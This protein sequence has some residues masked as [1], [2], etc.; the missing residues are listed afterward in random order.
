MLRCKEIAKLLS[1]SLDKDL[2]RW[3]KIEI[4]MHLFICRVCR[5]YWKQLRFL[6]KCVLQYYENKLKNTNDEKLSD[7]MKKS[8]QLQI[9]NR[10]K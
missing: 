4:R 10:G 6:H 1:N 3:Q 7:E 8:I 5:R 9:E 2:S